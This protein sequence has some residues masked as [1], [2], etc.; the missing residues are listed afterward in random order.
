MS[1]AQP[2]LTIAGTAAEA[3]KDTIA[4]AAAASVPFLDASVTF[5]E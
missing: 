2:A 3:D 4:V 1:I 5:W